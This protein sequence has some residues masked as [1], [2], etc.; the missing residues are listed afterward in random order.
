MNAEELTLQTVCKGAM[1]ALIEKHVR[2]VAAN[3]ADP[4]TKA[5]DVRKI[6]VEIA[7]KPYPDRSGATVTSKVRSSLAEDDLTEL[8]GTVFLAKH[9]G[10]YAL[11]TRDLRQEQLFFDDE[12]KSETE[13]IPD[14]KTASANP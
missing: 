11:F 2:K 6:L 4:N 10:Q 14:G 7:F 1:P 12:A 9:E 13:V 8:T 3:M 5:S